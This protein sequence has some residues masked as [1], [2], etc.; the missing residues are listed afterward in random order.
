MI[1]VDRGKFGRIAVKRG[2]K[3]FKFQGCKPAVPHLEYDRDCSNVE[4]TFRPSS[5]DEDHHMNQFQLARKTTE[6][7][8]YTLRIGNKENLLL[9]TSDG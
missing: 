5:I 1:C 8:Q 4:V 2:G 7:Y 3:C 9:A 6:I